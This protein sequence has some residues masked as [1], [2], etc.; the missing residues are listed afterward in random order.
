MCT[1]L[2]VPQMFVVL[3]GSVLFPSSRLCILAWR[4][5]IYGRPCWPI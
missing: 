3:S 1:R 4:A 2:Y 5:S